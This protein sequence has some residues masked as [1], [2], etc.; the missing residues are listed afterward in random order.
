[1]AALSP[2]CVPAALYFRLQKL[3]DKRHISSRDFHELTSAYAFLRHLEHRL[4]LRQGQQVHHLP[5]SE[6]E[7][8]VLRRS[9]ES[10]ATGDYRLTD[11]T[12]TVQQRMAAVAE[13]YQRVI[14]AQEVH[15]PA[16]PEVGEF[17]LR[18]LP[19]AEVADQSH[20]E[21]LA[22]LAEDAPELS[23]ALKNETPGSLEHKNLL[24]FLSSA[25][26]SSER[27]AT[28]LRHQDAVARS[29]P[30]FELSEYLTGTLVRYPEEVSAL[31]EIQSS[32]SRLIGGNLFNLS[33][34]DRPVSR[35]PVFAYVASSVAEQREKI[36]LL[37]RHFRHC[38]FT[39]GARDIAELRPIYSSLAETTTAA[40]E[41]ITAA[42]GIAGAP[43]GL[44]VLSLGR[45]GSREFDLLS[46]ADL[47][48]V[49]DESQDRR[50]LTKSAEHMMQALSA[51]TQE[52]MV[53]PVDTRLRPRGGEGELLVTPSHLEE[54]LASEAQ[55]WEALMYTK[56]RPICGDAE[57]G[58]RACSAAE[59]IFT[60]FAGDSNFPRAVRQM[61]QR[62]ED[63][64]APDKSIRTSPG[65][66]YD[67]DFLSSFLLVKHG[68]RPKLGT[69]RDRLW[70]C[71][72]AGVLDKKDAALLDHAAELC[73]TVEHVLRLVVGRNTRWLP[74]AE[75]ARHA[76]E[77]LTGQILHRDSPEGL[78]RDLLR[79]F[80]DVRIIYDRVVC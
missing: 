19:E 30:L 77:K 65:A 73:R 46:D 7:M 74:S 47:L 5:R 1:M 11:L 8:Q 62:L 55:P 18:S 13:I 34:D 12:A 61:R 56:L 23:Q 3:H 2:G 4:Q 40:E 45:V 41:A 69:L 54:Y 70:R 50:A 57:L 22:R 24:R 66:L 52:G 16:E 26:S 51:Y 27:Y 59:N 60:R 53:F 78:E 43:K 15:R 39:S 36:A 33:P 44:A 17:Q 72:A 80:A 64:S 71:S 68:I 21:L 63:A 79:T 29:L 25:F 76:A 58:R 37:R 20:Q 49:C 28:V 48:F 31:A 42:F 14:Y 67:A 32:A 9:M 6:Y 38:M 35:D 10:L 75:H